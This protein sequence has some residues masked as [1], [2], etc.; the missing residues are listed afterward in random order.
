MAEIAPELV[1]DDEEADEDDDDDADADALAAELAGSSC[2]EE[3]DM[4]HE[5]GTCSS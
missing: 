3:E 4:T 1:E 5:S 2:E